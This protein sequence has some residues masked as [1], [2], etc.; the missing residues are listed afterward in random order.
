MNLDNIGVST[1][2]DST[3][4]KKIQFFSKSNPTNL[5]NVKSDFQNSFKKLNNYY[6]T[7]L[8][9]NESY[10]YGMDRQHTHTS[11]SSTLPNFSTLLDQNSINKFFNYNFNF[12]KNY[13]PNTLELNRFNYPK[14][15]NSTSN[16]EFLLGNI[17]KLLPSK[18]NNI[19]YTDFYTFLAVPNN[20][21]VLGAENDSKQYSN[22]F[23][24]L[25]N[26]KH[27]K[28]S[29]TNYNYI[30][31]TLPNNDTFTKSVDPTNNFN[32]QLYNTENTLKFKDYKS[33]NAQFLGSERTVRLLTNVNSNTFKWN[34]SYSPNLPTTLENNLLD[35]GKSQNYVYSTSL[36]N[37]SDFNKYLRFG[38]NN[39]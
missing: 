30:L 6:L 8:A 18:L 26:F 22:S 3:A 21:S 33:S 13:T 31:N 11:L 17:H 28:K 1:I 10:T 32:S 14:N 34:T 12:S 36:S 38:N 2:K 29:L 35:Y 15:N 25:L 19:N 37:W 27:K 5:F 24:F 16:S 9:L 39:I 23:K 20:T 7:D 4:F